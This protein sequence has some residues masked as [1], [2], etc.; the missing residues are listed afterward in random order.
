M[1]K[2]NV[3]VYI[4]IS[5]TSSPNMNI[6][7][8]STQ[9]DMWKS[10]HAE[11][12]GKTLGIWYLMNSSSK[13]CVNLISS[14]SGGEVEE[15]CGGSTRRRVQRAVQAYVFQSFIRVGSKSSR[16]SLQLIWHLASCGR[17]QHWMKGKKTKKFGF[18]MFFEV[19]SILP[20]HREKNP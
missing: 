9:G 20:A 8:S 10:C 6:I 18:G 11:K 4:H 5:C 12:G 15:W 16:I 17:C 2:Y 3:Y 7:D 19:W 14:H 13:S 1:I